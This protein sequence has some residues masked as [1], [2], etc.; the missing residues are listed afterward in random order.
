MRE[1]VID[2]V[3]S[4][5]TLSGD[6]I[7]SSPIGI[8]DE[9]IEESHLDAR[10]DPTA[11][12]VLS[13]NSVGELEWVDAGTG[14]GGA[15]SSVTGGLGLTQDQTTGAVTINVDVAQG[16]FPVIPVA[17]GGTGGNTQDSAYTGL[18][19]RTVFDAAS[20]DGTSREIVYGLLGGGTH[21]VLINVEEFHGV[22]WRHV[23]GS[24]GL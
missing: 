5:S 3:T 4:D 24:E 14:V 7:T 21:E 11:G 22:G 17:K 20:W 19:I 13:I 16:D 23:H 12:Q 10:N 8:A 15:V 1:A 2:R 18:G 6:G 9:A